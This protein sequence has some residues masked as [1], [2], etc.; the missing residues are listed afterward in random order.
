M[1]QERLLNISEEMELDLLNV[2][3]ENKWRCF[4]NPMCTTYIQLLRFEKLHV[5]GLYRLWAC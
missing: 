5:E 2:D 3:T 1:I 4:V